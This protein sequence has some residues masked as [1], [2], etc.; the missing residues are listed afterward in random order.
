ML[1]LSVSQLTTVSHRVSLGGFQMLRT[2]RLDDDGV[3]KLK[4]KPKRY[5]VPDPELRGH[6]VR[7][8]PTGVKSYWVV[9]R[10][11]TGK[12]RWR[13]I[14]SPGQMTIDQA[15]DEARKVILSIRGSEPTSFTTVSAQWLAMHVAK[16]RERTYKEYARSVRRM[17]DAWNGRDFAA[18]E[19]DDLA[20]LMDKVEVESGLRSANYVLQVFSSLANWYATRSRHYRSPVVKGMY[21]GER[22][23]RSRILNDDELRAVWNHAADSYA[24]R[25]FGALVRFALL[26]AQRQDKLVSVK[27][28]HIKGDVWEIETEDGEKGN[29][30]VLELPSAALDVIEEQRLRRDDSPYVFAAER[31]G[32]HFNS[33]SDSKDA[34]DAVVNIPHW[35]IHDLRRTARSLMSRAGVLPHISERVMGHSIGGV[36]GVYDR[37]AYRAEKADALKRL[38]QQI[39]DVVVPP[40]SN[41]RRLRA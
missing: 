23:A 36:E 14:G 12:Q 39:M 28:E 37:Y 13:A 11:P 34:M 19:R 33:W 32:G 4:A 17:T 15:R 24:N 21:R 26:T 41:V 10:D 18:I 3:A 30:G 1:A 9:T 40:P 35:T 16:K 31:N 5:A 8:T 22:M 6:Y 2:K 29:A 25:T 38:A 7:I 27:W 20:K